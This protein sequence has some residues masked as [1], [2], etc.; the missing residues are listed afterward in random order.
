MFK[1]SIQIK[2]IKLTLLVILFLF[3]SLNLLFSEKAKSE[4]KGSFFWKTESKT[5]IVY[6]VGS[7]HIG[8]PDMYPLP[9]FIETAFNKSDYLTLVSQCSEN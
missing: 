6:L 4:I 9:E 8:R 2:N 1:K 3:Q 5:A 7:I